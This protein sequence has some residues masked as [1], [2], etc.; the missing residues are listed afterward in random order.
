MSDSGPDRK[1][2]DVLSS[3][4]RLVSSELP[5]NRRPDLPEGPGA[6]VLTESQ[7]IEAVRSTRGPRQSLED[8]IAELEA[9]VT[10]RGGEFEP[11]GSEDQAQN[12]PDRIVVPVSRPLP[13]VKPD[14]APEKVST[15]SVVAFRHKDESAETDAA[16]VIAPGTEAPEAEPPKRATRS[17]GAR[18][19]DID[20]VLGTLDAGPGRPAPLAEPPQNCEPEAEAMEEDRVNQ[21]DTVESSHD[22]DAEADFGYTGEVA[23]AAFGDLL[24]TDVAESVAEVLS[25]TMSPMAPVDDQ[26]R[27]AAE[28]PEPGALA[29]LTDAETLRP[30]VAQLIRE[31]LQGDLGERIT[32]NVRKLVRREILRALNARDVE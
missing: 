13:E 20:E 19:P 14:A 17:L 28:D 32:R 16:P 30:L 24:E 23:A 12:R 27:D 21:K 7:R 11:D 8:R 5:R 29:A 1:V 26:T 6:L 4:R 15:P 31:E 3:V 10:A 22:F 25:E 9:A 18:L 2:E